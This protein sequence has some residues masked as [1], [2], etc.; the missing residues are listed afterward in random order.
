VQCRDCKECK[1]RLAYRTLCDPCAKKTKRCPACCEYKSEEAKC[2]ASLLCRLA[3]LG[4]W[5]VRAATPAA[6]RVRNGRYDGGRRPAN[7][8]LPSTELESPLFYTRCCS[9]C[10]QAAKLKSLMRKCGI[11][12]D[13]E[14]AG[15]EEVAA[16]AAASVAAA[17]GDLSALLDDLEAEETTNAEEG[18]DSEWETDEDD[19]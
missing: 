19:E 12:S 8:R 16:A 11:E 15:E 14:T 7:E 17:G 9:S 6:Q 4:W 3:L 13:D 1:I 5:R 18:D 10:R 2:A